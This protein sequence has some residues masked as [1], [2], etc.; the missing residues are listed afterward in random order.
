MKNGINTFCLILF[1]TSGALR[2]Q[3][4]AA[5]SWP[6]FRGPNAAGIGTNAD[7]PD[8]WSDTENV[9]WK[10]DLPGRSWSSPVVWGE[11]V[12][13]T[14]VVNSGESEA[15]KKGLYFGGERPEPS[16]AEHL[17]QVLCLDLVT[18]KLQWEKTVHRGPP[19]TPI[20]LKSSYGAETPVTDGER[21]FALFGNVGVFALAFDG[22]ELW[23]KRLEPRQTRYG[24]GT[25][26]SPVLHGGRL[27][28]VNDNDEQAEL[29]A[30]DAK[31]G[32]ELWRVDRDE[33]SNWATPFLWDTG[34]RTE[35]ITSGSRAVRSYDLAGNLLWSFRGMSGIAIPTPCAGDGLL[36]VSSGYVGDKLRP[37]YATRLSS[38]IARRSTSTWRLAFRLSAMARK[39]MSMPSPMTG[40]R[41][42]WC[43][44]LA[45]S[46]ACGWTRWTA[47]AST[48]VLRKSKSITIPRPNP[49][50]G[51]SMPLRITSLTSTDRTAFH[52]MTY[53]EPA[54]ANLLL[55][56]GGFVGSVSY[57]DGQAELVSPTRLEGSHGM[58]DRLWGGPKLIQDD[59]PGTMVQGAFEYWALAQMAEE[60][61]HE[62]DLP[63]YQVWI[64]G[65]KKYF[66]PKQNL[67]S[68]RRVEAN[69]WQG[70][71]GVAHDI[72]GLAE[73]MGGPDVLAGMLNEA[74]EE[75]RQAD[76]V[77]T[78][79]AGKISY[80]NQPGCANAH[81]FN[82]VGSPWLSQYWV[83]RVSRQAYGGTNPNRGYG[84]HD[85][86]QGQM[87]GVSALMKL[88]LL[89]LWLGPEPNRKWGIIPRQREYP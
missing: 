12:F 18:G 58:T 37:L 10:T 49:I 59:G 2:S 15:P 52:R 11:R 14:A 73:L 5:D 87:G 3:A 84:G 25:A 26:A 74:F 60:M 76:F 65:S 22:T 50:S 85:E 45:P 20:H 7:L 35:L 67:L 81:V 72:A 77:Y 13:L 1:A 38:T 41:S 36:F 55:Q 42:P 39:W 69:D 16:K 47:S 6:Q 80:A 9:A 40:P 79:G 75:E 66:D 43:S 21:L 48:R 54:R 28:L 62:E 4:A 24:W 23:S 68:G 82:H 83:R 31:T 64:D 86:D 57:V 88:G 56:L 29:L 8:T 61:R 89:E 53:R 63:G 32:R 44:N 30:L 33:K 71:F 51:E 70:T 46:P 17:W 27:F 34:Q 19:P 78:Y